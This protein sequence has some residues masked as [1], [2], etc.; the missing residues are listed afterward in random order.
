VAV[1]QGC[2]GIDKVPSGNYFCRACTHFD[3]DK[4]FLAAERRRGPRTKPTRPHINCELCPRRNGAFVLVQSPEP[5]GDHESNEKPRKAK[6]VHV[7]CAK[8]HG[9][10]YV[11]IELKDKIEDVSGLKDWFK[12]AGHQCC[13]CESSIGAMHQCRQ[14]GCGKWLHLTCGRSIGT[15]SVQHGENCFGFY[16]E[17]KLNTP[18][19][20]LA[21]PK[22]S[23]VDTESIRDDSLTLEQ[24]VT[25]AKSYPP[26]PVPPK[27][28]YKMSGAERVEYWSDRGNLKE[29]FGKVMSNLSG[30]KCAIC[31]MAHDPNDPN[32]A[33]QF[34]PK[35]G[36]FSHAECADPAR[37]EDGICFSC[38]F[39]DDN[40]NSN[41]Y[42]EPKCQLCNISNPT[43]GP[44]VKT[45]A[46]PMSM[47]KWKENKAAFKRS[48][49]GPNNFC[50]TLCGL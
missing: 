7:S 11:D 15:C 41:D 30:A 2:Y 32:S 14:E 33:N 46:K 26:E 44:L 39:V 45:F 9:M 5:I 20:T 50:H 23:D 36:V 49:Y 35:C 37:G 25:I 24:L 17:T 38:R 22:H 47:K 43:G 12:A 10:N 18:P 42:V 28:F 19:W 34:C 48:L 4:E 3:I 8:W 40:K 13:L 27:P 21:C 29:F 1:H 16:D 6:W 31:E